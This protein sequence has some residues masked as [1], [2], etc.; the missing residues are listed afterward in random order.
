M[1]RYLKQEIKAKASRNL[2]AQK[3]FDNVCKKPHAI[4]QSQFERGGN[5]D[6][7]F[8]QMGRD[9]S[10]RLSRGENSVSTAELVYDALFKREC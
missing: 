6:A 9:F 7:I 10:E 3:D 5:F 1:E 8:V 2:T 4:S